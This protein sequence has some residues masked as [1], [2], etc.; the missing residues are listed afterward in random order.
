MEPSPL[1]EISALEP[2]SAAVRT[3]VA[4]SLS[5]PGGTRAAVKAMAISAVALRFPLNH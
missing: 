3:A 5:M 1:F 4:T 2:T